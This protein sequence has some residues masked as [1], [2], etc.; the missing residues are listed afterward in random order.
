MDLQTL[1][2]YFSHIVSL[3]KISIPTPSYASKDYSLTILAFETPHLL[4][5]SNYLHRAG[6]FN[7]FSGSTHCVQ[8]ISVHSL[9]QII[10]NS[11][12]EDL[13]PKFLKAC[14]VL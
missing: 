1:R 7:I 11:A 4:G 6:I 9:W 13:S 3:R 12:W 5:I 14:Y 2:T 10:G 8:K